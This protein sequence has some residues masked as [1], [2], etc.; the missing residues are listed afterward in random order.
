[1]LLSRLALVLEQVGIMASIRHPNVVLFMGMCIEPPCLVSEW[2]SRGSVYD[3]LAKA[4]KQPALAAQLP[5]HRRLHMALDA[6]KVSSQHPSSPHP[7][8]VWLTKKE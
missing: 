4:A 7:R 2:C 6:A 3:I 8:H 5:W 1:M